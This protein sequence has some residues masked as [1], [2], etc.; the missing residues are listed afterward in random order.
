M[1]CNN[2]GKQNPDSAKF[3]SECGA[4]VSAQMINNAYKVNQ[5]GMKRE[6]TRNA[7]IMET[8]RMIRYFSQKEASYNEY[9][10]LCA[11]LIKFSKGKRHAL[12]I[13]GI[14]ISVFGTILFSLLTA[15][16]T[17][18]ELVVSIIPFLIGQGMIIGYIAYSIS[19][20]KKH[21][22]TKERFNTVSNE[23]AEHYSN[24]GVCAVGAE[25]TNPSNLIAILNTI[26]SGR[27][28]TIKEALNVLIDDVYRNN[29]RSL[30]V[31][32]ARNTASAARAAKANIFFNAANFFTKR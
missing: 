7:E 29:M 25:Y 19:F 6:Q 20:G 15:K 24:Y 32:T 9:D 26:K 2:C 18:P 4:P 21:K 22:V 23:L 10:Y 13:W 17:Y 8:E 30:A 14:I 11:Q 1:F 31:Q 12:L 5:H 28:D 3:C 27:A 16:N